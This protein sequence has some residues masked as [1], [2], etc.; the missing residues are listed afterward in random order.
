MNG[1]IN[2]D[3]TYERKISTFSP[4]KEVEKV[5][6]E[7]V[8]QAQIINTVTNEKVINEVILKDKNNFEY[9]VLRAPIEQEKNSKKINTKSDLNFNI[10]TA[11]QQEA[12]AQLYPQKTETE[13]ED[14]LNSPIEANRKEEVLANQK[15]L[16]D[17]NKRSTNQNARSTSPTETENVL[18]SADSNKSK[19]SPSK[20]TNDFLYLQLSYQNLINQSILD[21]LKDIDN[22][23]YY[24]D[25]LDKLSQGVDGLKDDFQ[26]ILD[27]MNKYKDAY[28]DYWMEIYNQI[29]DHKFKTK[30]EVI[31]FLKNKDI[32]D[33][34]IK[35]LLST[36]INSRE[37]MAAFLKDNF[38]FI[39]LPDS[40]KDYT[41][42]DIDKLY[43]KLAQF[44]NEAFKYMPNVSMSN[45]KLNS[46]TSHKNELNSLINKKNDDSIKNR[47]D[48][49][50]D[51]YQKLTETQSKIELEV[52]SHSL[53]GMA[54]LT[55][56]LAKLRE[57]TLKVTLERAEGEQ[58]LFD[59]MQEVTTKTLKEKIEDQKAQI[60]K[61]EE[62]QYWAGIGLKIL[63]GL[64]T[65]IAGIASI[66][67]AGA[68]L[69]LVGVA[70]VMMAA[71]VTLTVADEIYQAVNNKS[72]ME[73]AMAPV[74]EAIGE[75]VDKIVDAIVDM[76]NSTLD[77]LVALGL[78]KNT[79]QK[80]KEAMQEKLKMA[81]KIIVTIGL[82]VGG[83][84]LSF[85]AG[86]AANMVTNVAKKIFT[87]QVKMTLKKMMHDYLEA[88]LGKMVKE[89]IMETLENILK[90]INKVLSK[91]L[92]AHGLKTL[93]RTVVMSRLGTAS[94]SS[95]VN[96]YTA[97]I[98][99]KIIRSVADTKKLQAI[100]DMIQK[101]IEKIMDSYHD[102]VETLTEILRNMSDNL[103]VSNKT[104]ANIVKN[105]TI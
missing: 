10:K 3:I 95:A 79:I 101:L 2:N 48:G 99:D 72:F 61:Q 69:A 80:A 26:S 62:I 81:V 78:D 104:R 31:A 93:N 64:L 83:V 65:L 67:T 20:G 8:K 103:S 42:A 70:V 7:S 39:N 5:N 66:F 50:K 9:P 56:L 53:S 37:E 54:L 68:S 24:L 71:S 44:L 17:D 32:P 33:S 63:G 43:N 23:D 97:T 96:I 59:E 18:L 13:R 58:K 100:L 90:S 77:A 38:P 4:S 60:K 76:L 105:I 91:D 1:K 47:L 82:L 55:F 30:E 41:L 28:T 102:Q 14:V 40:T 45:D 12:K 85:V 49:A 92:T 74:T 22:L 16:Y 94:A 52:A 87:E 46:I 89:I 51:I 86:S 11:E 75:V 29:K 73:E 34:V 15:H 6:K 57:L 21:K 36:K 88:M 35:K 25:K 98:T 84:A 27:D 19:R